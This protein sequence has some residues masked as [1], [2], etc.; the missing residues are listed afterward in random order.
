MFWSC[1]DI[2]YIILSEIHCIQM[3]RRCW[4][5]L[6]KARSVTISLPRYIFKLAVIYLIRLPYQVHWLTDTVFKQITYLIRCSSKPAVY[7]ITNSS[8]KN[9]LIFFYHS[10][11]IFFNSI[12]QTASIYV[13]DY[14]EY[15]HATSTSP[16]FLL[17]LMMAPEFSVFWSEA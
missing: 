17:L 14:N 4:T 9:I 3:Y 6:L 13:R 1:F 11:F 2:I 12:L 5:S 7:C 16:R 15:L 10:S 8:K